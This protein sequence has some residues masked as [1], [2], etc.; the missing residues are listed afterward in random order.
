MYGKYRGP[1]IIKKIKLSSE[2]IILVSDKDS[3]NSLVYFEV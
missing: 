3:R 1:Q 2:T